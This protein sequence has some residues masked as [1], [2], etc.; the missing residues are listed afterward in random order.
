[1]Y[2]TDVEMS[3]TGKLGESWWELCYFLQFFYKSKKILKE[4]FYLK[5][6]KKTVLQY[7][8]A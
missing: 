4:C 2:H 1:M 5:K 6:Q 3:V 8:Q 7:T